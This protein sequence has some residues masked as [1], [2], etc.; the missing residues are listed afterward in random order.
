MYNIVAKKTV[1]VRVPIPANPTANVEYKFENINDLSGNNIIIYGIQ[2]Y[3]AAQLIKDNTGTDV[4]DATASTGIVVNIL[5]SK[6]EY[7][8]QNVPYL[9]FIKQS[10]S[11]IVFLQK[12]LII[13][14]TDCSIS[15]TSKLGNVAGGGATSALF[16]LFYE[17]VKA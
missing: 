16:K 5:N 4:V 8:H 1:V 11:G 9:D 7:I 2:A 3:N 14:L 17:I 13:S 12:P 10:N 15:I 6:S